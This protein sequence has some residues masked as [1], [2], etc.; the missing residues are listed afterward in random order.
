MAA[1]SLLHDIAA[2]RPEIAS[3]TTESS[4][5]TARTAAARSALVDLVSVL[6]LGRMLAALPV[7][8]ARSRPMP[9]PRAP[10]SA[11]R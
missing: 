10:A 8:S 4:I 7:T 3:L 11:R 9:Q 6:S 2:I 5:G 1:A